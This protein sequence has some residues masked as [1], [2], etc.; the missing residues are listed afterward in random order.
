MK[1]SRA[2]VVWGTFQVIVVHLTSP[3][4]ISMKGCRS[5]THARTRSSQA[6][7]EPLLL[8][9]FFRMTGTLSP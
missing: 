6:I 1:V 7:K 2:D 8:F 9:C 3:L 5:G 4:N